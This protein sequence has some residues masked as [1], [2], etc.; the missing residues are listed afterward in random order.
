MPIKLSTE[1][2]EAGPAVQF[3]RRKFFWL[4]GAGAATLAA[5]EWAFPLLRKHDLLTQT[6][7]GNDVQPTAG[8]SVAPDV[9][10]ALTAS[11][12]TVPL[13]PG[14]PT[15]VWQYTG[16]VLRGDPGCLQVAP[17]SYLGPTLRLRQGQKVRIHFTNSLSEA[18]IIHWHGLHMPAE[19]DGH[20]RS[21]ITPGQS[22]QYDFEVTNRPGTYW[23]HP[24]PHDRTGPQVYRGLAGLLIVEDD[25]AKSPG[26]PS[27]KYDIPLVIQDR[28]VDEN[29]QF[30]YSTSG[31]MGKMT[32]FLGDRILVNGQ[33]DFA[34]PV[35]TRAY[36]LRLLNA[37]NSRVYKLAWSDG[38][39]LT[40]VGTDGG[41]LDKPVKRTYVTLAP[42]ERIE[43]FV[44]FRKYPLNAVLELHSLEFSSA[45]GGM[46]MM[47][48]NPDLPNGAPFSV[49]K[50]QVTRQE[51]ET[52]VL[53]AAFAPSL[54]FR[55]ADAVNTDAPRRFALSMG[56][57][58]WLLN[59]R[60]FVMDEVAD[61][62]TVRL[63]TLELWEFVNDARSSSA[64]GG[65]GMMGGM[66]LAHPIHI[67]NVQFQV[68]GRSVD[69]E[70][71]SQW[72]TLR[73]GFVDEGWKDTVLVMPGETVKLLLRFEK[74]P[75][76][77]LY[78][79]HNLEHEDMG[80]MRNYRILA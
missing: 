1:K 15:R 8:G 25:P 73:G 22:F 36:R 70:F 77:F 18:S 35:A 41:L 54:R 46:G 4:V 23:Y 26:L 17:G 3:D 75:G 21:V 55:A 68:I 10:I 16:K 14:A 9:E 12:G 62:E 71:A 72:Q 56:H 2:L 19:M 60:S 50:V 69:P 34:L 51:K 30:V 37:S 76:V 52:F 53:P 67:H 5:G 61:N 45:A 33:P 6:G 31:M 74:Y 29:N 47:G 32:G 38:T 78:H 27:G 11:T 66:G 58:K 59:G 43:L 39:P 20:P 48:A 28:S 79:C 63:N 64:G 7:T 65:M 49:L 57:M 40:V 44:D 80:M 42:A 13:F 24:H